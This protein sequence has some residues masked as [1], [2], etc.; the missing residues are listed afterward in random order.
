MGWI[1]V[2]A[3]EALIKEQELTRHDSDAMFLNQIPYLKPDPISS[4]TVA[5]CLIAKKNSRRLS[6]CQ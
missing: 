3:T 2:V 5:R 1:E 4:A 6:E